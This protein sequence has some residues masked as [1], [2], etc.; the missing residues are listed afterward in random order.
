MTATTGTVNQHAPVVRGTNIGC[1]AYVLINPLMTFATNE[2]CVLALTCEYESVVAFTFQS[3]KFKVRTSGQTRGTQTKGQQNR[4]KQI[5]H[6]RLSLPMRLR[7]RMNVCLWQNGH[8]GPWAALL[9]ML[10]S[11]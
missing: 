8:M 2:S 9:K 7:W 1:P 10:Q 4:H 3:Q 6:T 5:I 11:E